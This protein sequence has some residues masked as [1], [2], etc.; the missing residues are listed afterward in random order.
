MLLYSVACGEFKQ[1]SI[2]DFLSSREVLAGFCLP[3]IGPRASPVGI[4][5]CSQLFAASGLSSHL[6]IRRSWGVAGR[7]SCECFFGS[8]LAGCCE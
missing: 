5:G 7:A 6:F 2:S 1:L 4:W 3:V 8:V